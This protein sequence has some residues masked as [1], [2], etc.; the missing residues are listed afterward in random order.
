MKERPVIFNTDM[1]KAILD[2]RKTQTRRVIKSQPTPE[3]DKIEYYGDIG[4]GW[5]PT[6][7]SGKIG[8][9]NPPGYKCPYG[10]F[11]EYNFL[12]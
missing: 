12:R 4:W 10:S 6:S 9:F 5:I 8:I 2:G 11:E 7:K 3:P 1:V